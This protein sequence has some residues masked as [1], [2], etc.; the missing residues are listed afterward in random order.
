[1]LVPLLVPAVIIRSIFAFNQFYLFQV[2]PTG[3][4]TL[5]GLSYNLFNPSGFFINGQFAISA[6]INVITVVILVIFVVILNKW[7]NA[8][9]GVTYA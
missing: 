4:L 7:S 8:S 6:V 5:A 3:Q 2:F 1:M 9:E